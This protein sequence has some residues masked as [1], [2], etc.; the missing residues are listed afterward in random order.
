MCNSLK[1]ENIESRISIAK[2]NDI[3]PVIKKDG[4]IENV[5]WLG[6]I[7]EE[8]GIPKLQHEQVSIPVK[9]YTE[10]GIE[11]KVQQ[12]QFLSGYV[13]HSETYPNKKGLFIITRPVSKEELEYCKHYRHPRIK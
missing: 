9:A 2:I 1:Y 8:S 10:K 13:I 3:I 7:R 11:F 6:H 12:N 4:S 5:Q